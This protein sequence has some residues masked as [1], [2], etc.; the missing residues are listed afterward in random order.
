[1]ICCV[2]LYLCTIPT[3]ITVPNSNY[4]HCC[5][6][7]HACLYC[8]YCFYFH[9]CLYCHFFNYLPLPVHPVTLSPAP[10][11]REPASLVKPLKEGATDDEKAARESKLTESKPK[12]AA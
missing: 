8:H 3:I 10:L 12:V 2:L 4:C 11:C 6:F 5:Y 9:K 1:M 7:C